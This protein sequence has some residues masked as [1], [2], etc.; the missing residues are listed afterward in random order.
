MLEERL[1]LCFQL[2]NGS[3][4]FMRILLPIRLDLFNPLFYLGD[5]KLD[6]ILFL[7]QFFPCD[8]LIAQLRENRRL[9]GAF[10]SEIYFAFLQEAFFVTQ[11]QARSLAPDFQRDLTK[12]CANETHRKRLAESVL[13]QMQIFS[14]KGETSL[15]SCFTLRNRSTLP[16][17]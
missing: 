3:I 8:D 12:A 2:R 13:T 16:G 5:S 11:G 10:A 7:L 15:A 4:L 1:L 17:R 9:R 14:P 6:L